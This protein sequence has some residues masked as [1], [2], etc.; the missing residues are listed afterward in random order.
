MTSLFLLKLGAAVLIFFMAFSSGLLPALMNGK[1]AQKKILSFGESFSGGV[2]LSAAFLHLLPEGAEKMEEAYP[3]LDFPVVFLLCAV[4]ILCL[5]VL[6]KGLARYFD[7][8]EAQQP[9]WLAYILVI[10][11]SVH[12][13]IAGAALGITSKLADL[14]IIGIAIVA[15][16]G[17]EAFALGSHLRKHHLSRE[18][19]I[20]V[21]VLFSLMTPIG[22]AAGSFV[23]QLLSGH[24]GIVTEGV[25]NG[26]A[27]GTFIYIAT[28]Y[29]FE[30]STELEHED[31]LCHFGFFAFGM[32]IMAAVAIWV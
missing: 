21:L 1:G 11:L 13:V 20:R 19:M 22:I 8:C 24:S 7:R 3:N 26:V 28:Q 17:A 29:H 14:F 12:S 10:L 6:E 31:T 25:F 27:A 4:T 16:K 9:H 32:A 18:H 2:F 23:S 30:F 5:R 15:H